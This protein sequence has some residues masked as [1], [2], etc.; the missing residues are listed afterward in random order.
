MPSKKQEEQ[1]AGELYPQPTAEIHKKQVSPMQDEVPEATSEVKTTV[2]LALPTRELALRLLDKVDYTQRLT[3]YKIL[4]MRKA[5]EISICNLAEAIEFVELCRQSYDREEFFREE[6]RILI[7]RL[8]L[9][10]LRDWIGQTL[11]DTELATAITDE[12]GEDCKSRRVDKMGNDFLKHAVP[13]KELI[14]QRLEQCEDII[15]VY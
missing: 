10:S 4:L 5:E 9:N 12:I 15:G 8:D 11:G 14:Q 2:Q 7:A 1:S 13:I 6:G 3:G